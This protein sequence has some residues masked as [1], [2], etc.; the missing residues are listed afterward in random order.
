MENGKVT[1]NNLEIRRLFT[2]DSGWYECQIPTKPTQKTYIY[3]EV[4]GR[5][6]SMHNVIQPTLEPFPITCIFIHNN[7][8]GSPK[9][10][11]NVTTGLR[12]G[13][14]VE[15]TCHVDYLPARYKLN[16]Y[17]DEKN[18]NEMVAAAE[19]VNRSMRN[20][21]ESSSSSSSSLS[22]SVAPVLPY[23]I[24][25]VRKRDCTLTRLTII[26]F[27]EVH[28]RRGRGVYKCKYDAGPTSIGEAVYDPAA[29]L[30]LTKSSSRLDMFDSF[31]LSSS[32]SSSSSSSLSSTQSHSAGKSRLLLLAACLSIVSRSLIFNSYSSINS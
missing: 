2:S 6:S 16:W 28:S 32:L 11:A 5:C 4:L 15:L 18:L 7:K 26:N 23:R 29:R 10:E 30:K 9:I 13:D 12:S 19:V 17:L 24:E 14:T 1:S 22:S 27:T 31:L 20:S 3:L 25:A 8:I 21:N